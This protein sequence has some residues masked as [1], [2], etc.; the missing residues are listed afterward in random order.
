VHGALQPVRLLANVERAG[1]RLVQEPITKP[2]TKLSKH[3]KA[4]PAWIHLA[5]RDP[6]VELTV[7][8]DRVGFEASRPPAPA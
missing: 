1:Y 8:D 4:T 5:P 7:S 2:I 3:A 6:R